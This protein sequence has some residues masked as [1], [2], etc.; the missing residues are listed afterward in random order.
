MAGGAL[1]TRPASSLPGSGRGAGRS[2]ARR[3]P[4]GGPSAIM[5]NDNNRAMIRRV[6]LWHPGFL[7]AKRIGCENEIDFR[8]RIFRRIREPRTARIS[9][10]VMEL[11]QKWLELRRFRMVRPRRYSLRERTRRLQPRWRARP[12]APRT[13]C[14]PIYPCVTPPSIQGRTA[15][16]NWGTKLTRPTSCG[17][18]G[19]NGS[20]ISPAD[21]TI[22]RVILG[23]Q[24]ARVKNFGAKNITE[25]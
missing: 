2:E 10:R 18:H 23:W 14:L 25:N 17:P 15:A 1:K 3:F 5:S 19:H 7:H 11:L 20:A 21:R 6:N 16:W 12:K 22:P 13:V 24:P 8:G 9:P 4:A